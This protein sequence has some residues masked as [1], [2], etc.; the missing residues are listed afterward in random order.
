MKLSTKALA[1]ILGLSILAGTFPM[2]N[3]SANAQAKKEYKLQMG[4][5][6]SLKKELSITGNAGFISLDPDYISVDSKGNVCGL[7]SGSGYVEVEDE[8]GSKKYEFTVGKKG[9][10]Y[11][12]LTM[13]KGEKANLNSLFSND[14][15]DIEWSSSKKKIAKVNKKGVVKAQAKGEA[16]IKGVAG[17]KTYQCSVK[18]EKHPKS[19]IY[20]TFDD[21]PT[22]SSTPKILNILKS[23]GVHATF[24]E[25]TPAKENYDL[26][27]RIIKEG[28][29]LAVHGYSHDYNKIYRSEKAYKNNLEKLRKLFFNKFNVWCTNSRFPGG[30]SNMVSHFNRGIMTRL[31]KLVPKW[32]YKYF[33]WNVSSS[34]AG[35]ARNKKQVFRSVKKGLKK[36]REN[37]VLMHDFNNNFKT[38][39][40]LKRIIKFGKNHGYEFRT[41]TPATTEVHHGINN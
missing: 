41:I 39:N 5:V 27:K 38:I 30:S 23:K 28:H 13:M 32:G 17:D 1:A 31:S 2:G 25:I 37:V 10:M 22:R 34:D 15:K 11:P 26:T 24:F 16:V 36:G 3:V 40:A 7:K 18:V 8:K 19:I 4:E 9:F 14:I 6:I 29:S 12:K 20:L 21:G 35:G 33:D